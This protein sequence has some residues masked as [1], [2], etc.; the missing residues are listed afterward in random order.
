MWFVRFV[1]NCLFLVCLPLFG[2]AAICFAFIDWA[3]TQTMFR[4]NWWRRIF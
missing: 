4:D 2:L 3:Q 1:G